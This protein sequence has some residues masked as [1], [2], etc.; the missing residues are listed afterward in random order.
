MRIP[1][2]FGT[3][4]LG[5]VIAHCGGDD[6]TTATDS[7]SPKDSSVA[8]SSKADSTSPTDSAAE[9]QVADAAPPVT[10]KT[11]F[12]TNK[13]MYKGDLG[14]VLGGD[15]ECQSA[16]TAAKVKGVFKAWL[17][18]SNGASP[19]K[20]FTQA[21]V[22][23]KLVDGTIVANDWADLIGG[24]LRASISVSE[25]GVTVIGGAWT[26]T[27]SDGTAMTAAN[28]ANWTDA[29]HNSKGLNGDVS[30]KAAG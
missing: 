5:V 16:A 22:P 4:I 24:T 21:T 10:S 27:A 9:A 12:V 28:C 18:D 6:S 2:V 29:T 19:A 13:G 25:T 8:D 3:F 26:S 1:I 11:V 15:K 20:T 14:G 23:Y 30:S 7:G 17:S